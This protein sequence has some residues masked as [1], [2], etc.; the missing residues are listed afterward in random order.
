MAKHQH[1]SPICL[2]VLLP[3]YHSATKTTAANAHMTSQNARKLLGP[4]A[5]NI[6]TTNMTAESRDSADNFA[7]SK[8][9]FL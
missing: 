3:T 4:S 1:L 9:H 7:I 5:T 2:G 8:S 6:C